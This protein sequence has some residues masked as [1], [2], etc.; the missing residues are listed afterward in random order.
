MAT[1]I[2]ITFPNFLCSKVWSH[3]S[4]LTSEIY[5]EMESPT[6]SRDLKGKQH[7]L[8]HPVFLSEG[9]NTDVMAGAGVPILGHK[10]TL[11]M[12]VMHNRI[13]TYHGSPL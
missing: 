9:W 2:K 10:V 12:E 5:L 4:G 1:Q 3:D 8:H 13:E 7:A 6:F 11:V